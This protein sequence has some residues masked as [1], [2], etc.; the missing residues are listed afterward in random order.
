[1][2]LF[3]IRHALC[4]P[5]GIS[6][7]G[8]MPGVSLNAA[9][10]AQLGP[11]VARV[12]RRL[13]GVPLDAVIA[14][15]LARAQ[16]TGGAVARAHGLAVDTEPG[17]HEIDVG[18]WT[19]REIDALG[20]D[21][22][23]APFNTYRSGTPA[24]GAELAIAAQARAVAALLARARSSP[25]AVIAAVSHGDVIRAVLCHALGVSLDLQHRVEVSP[26]SVSELELWPWGP[27]VLAINDVS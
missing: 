26:A 25:D 19:G 15:P 14:S 24:G 10:R 5:V 18:R 13:G 11:L 9:G 8:R 17:F 27:R 21:P 22:D 2:R 6:L 3:L 16:E 23:W 20:D 1:M 4:D 7:A 12:A